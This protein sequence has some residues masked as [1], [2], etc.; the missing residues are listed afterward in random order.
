MKRGYVPWTR[1]ELER[2]YKIYLDEDYMYK[3]GPKKGKPNI[4]MIAEEINITF[5]QN[6]RVRTYEAV[7]QALKR[8]RKK[9]NYLNF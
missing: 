3:S 8:Y 7:S 4:K 2:A 9:L 5:H 1:E 6:S